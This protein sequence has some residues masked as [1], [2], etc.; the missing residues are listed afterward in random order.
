MPSGLN[1]RAA[2]ISARSCRSI[3]FIVLLYDALPSSTRKFSSI[4]FS[5]I[6]PDPNLPVF[7]CPLGKKLIKLNHTSDPV[8]EIF[9]Q[10]AF[11]GRMNGI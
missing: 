11:V 4:P 6:T 7:P 9:Q 1:W 2:E 5:E 3:L 8:E 10:E